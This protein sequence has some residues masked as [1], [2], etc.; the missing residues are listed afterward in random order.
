[1][2]TARDWVALDLEATAPDPA[3]AHILEI[4]AQDMQ[5]HSRCWYVDTPEP[6]KPDHEAFRFTGMTSTSTRGKRYR[7][8]GR[9]RNSWTF[10][11]TAPSSAITCYA[12]TFPC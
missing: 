4:A 5:G 6:L 12:T 8:K 11:A 10:W 2:S 3:E 9:S 1:M 7:E